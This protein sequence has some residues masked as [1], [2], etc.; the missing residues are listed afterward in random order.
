MMGMNG[1]ALVHLIA[2]RKLR[3]REREREREKGR[4]EEGRGGER[5]EGKGISDWVPIFT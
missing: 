2:A 1:G 5:R 3:E 4:G